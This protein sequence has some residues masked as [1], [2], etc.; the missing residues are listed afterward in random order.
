[1]KKD[2]AK[3]LEAE[4]NPEQI[5]AVTHGLGPQLVL[6]G[7]GSGKTRVIT[8][9]IYWLIEEM[10][11]DPGHI[12]AMTFTNK[13]AGE[14]RERV[15]NLIGIHPLPTSVGTFH[16]YGLL[17]L[18]RYGERAG[19]RRDF[20][21]LDSAD[22]LGLVKE[23]LGTEGLSDSAFPPR[24]VLSQI[25]AAKNK[26]I[27]APAYE[28][29]ASN[30]FEKKI[31]A[32]YRRY[33]G[34]LSQ[35]SGVDFDDLI[36]LA[37]KLL[38]T[39]AELRERIRR[40][41][42]FLLVDEYQDTNHAQ[43]RLVQE[44]N[45]PEGNLTAVGDEDQGIYRW[46]GA[47]LNNI[48]EFEKTFPNAEVRKLERNYRSTQT[49]L[50]V[51]GALIAHNVNRRGKRLWT[52]SGAGV[53]A[54]LYKASDEGD[55]A[56]W[57]IRTL[58]RLRANY[59]LSEMAVLVRTNAQTRAI[60]DELL[61][62][63]IPY[64]LV[65]GVRFY[66]RAEIKDLVAYLRVLRNPRDNFSLM[67]I[68]NQP[69]R[70]IGKSTLELLRDRAVQLGQPLWDVLYLDDLG[71]LP[72][73]S[74]AALRKFR[75][76]IVGLQHTA[77][78]LPLP[79]LLDRLLEATAFTSLF[80]QDD[81]DDVARLEN[82]QEFLSAAQEFTEANSYNS[83]SDQD[84]LT[85]FLDHIALVSDLDA[86][87][88]EKGVSLMTLHSAKGLEFR[89]VVVAGLENGLLPHFNS[90]GAQEDVE[91]E[92]R[93]LYVGMT[94]A[95]ERLFLSCCRRRRIAGRYQDQMESPFLPELPDKLLNVTASPDLF[96]AERQ[97]PRAQDVYSFFSNPPR[98]AAAGASSPASPPSRPSLPFQPPPPTG[99]NRAPVPPPPPAGRRLV[100]D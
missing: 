91:E 39:D 35:A 27:D 5:A 42:R 97:N 94:R 4:L 100:P 8:Y 19:L 29:Q 57:I 30:F 40:R 92:R 60:E 49:I 85:T 69:P 20:H 17:L 3:E 79:A 18:R 53:K 50:D 86:L 89:A 16:R 51:S 82:I 76:L 93:L 32:L 90:Q 99:F 48:L 12:A 61:A 75:D 23:A 15:E 55:E 31:A 80:N 26:L 14:M 78:E 7:A 74:A 37:V 70:G 88:S 72:A 84:L 63:E 41:T 22:Q 54:E 10:G 43:L 58:Q 83:A 25:S 62:Q 98:P 33:Q 46:R 66:E 45:G 64:S 65:G 36:G 71:T 38:S 52:D 68:V 34:L 56:S 11:V 87:Q 96:Y 24:A 9:R 1:M 95:R 59:R 77:S 2:I 47:D 81:A 73:R 44:L 67:R 28:A 21:I 6:A 13:A